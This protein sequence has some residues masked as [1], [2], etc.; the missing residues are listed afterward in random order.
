[1][2]YLYTQTHT[3]TGTH[4]CTDICSKRLPPSG[5][6]NTPRWDVERPTL[7]QK[8]PVLVNRLWLPVHIG[9]WLLNWIGGLPLGVGE[10]A[11][12]SLL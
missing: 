8:R 4:T 12:S 10:T 9:C 2:S 3:C 6:E 5:F 11:P 1:M 7:S